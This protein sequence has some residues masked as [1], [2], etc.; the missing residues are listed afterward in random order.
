MLHVDVLA[1]YLSPRGS[2]TEEE[3]ALALVE[4]LQGFLHIV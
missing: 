2:E 3:R 4:Y 1:D